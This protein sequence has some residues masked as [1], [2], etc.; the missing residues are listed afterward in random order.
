MGRPRNSE[1]VVSARRQE[2]TTARKPRQA[3]ESVIRT[4][5]DRTA[6]RVRMDL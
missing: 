1:D 3:S 4:V 6:H 5:A 2:T